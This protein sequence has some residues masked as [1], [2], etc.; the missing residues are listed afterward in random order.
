MKEDLEPSGRKSEEDLSTNPWGIVGSGQVPWWSCLLGAVLVGGI[1]YGVVSIGGGIKDPAVGRWFSLA[2]AALGF[3]V[4][5]GVWAW[6]QV[7]CRWGA[8]FRRRKIDGQ[9]FG[10]LFFG[11]V[12][13]ALFAGL[14]YGEIATGN[15]QWTDDWFAMVVV[16]VFGL[17]FLGSL[18]AWR[19]YPWGGWVFAVTAM[20][21]VTV[22]ASSA[23][24]SGL[25][26]LPVPGRG[27]VLVLAIVW[28]VGAAGGLL[29]ALKTKDRP[30]RLP[31]P[32]IVAWPVMMVLFA[33]TLLLPAVLLV[34][35][36]LA[37]EWIGNRFGHPYIGA[38]AALGVAVA[39]AAIALGLG[40]RKGGPPGAGRDASAD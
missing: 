19:G 28:L 18:A 26:A 13:F 8:A 33:P 23:V 5:L 6:D 30:E 16:A 27:T 17:L 12:F 35:W 9:L 4:G 36:I 7:L 2:V 39:G 3:M 20:I 1:A 31:I 32:V 22:I 14:V 37:G 34:T 25:L 15:F 38:F 10:A 29:A 40:T 11:A 24:S 21:F